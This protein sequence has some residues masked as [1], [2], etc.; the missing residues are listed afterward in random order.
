MGRSLFRHGGKKVPVAV[1]AVDPPQDG[2]EVDILCHHV[3]YKGVTTL[4]SGQGRVV[5][6]AVLQCVQDVKGT[7]LW[8]EYPGG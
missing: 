6:D 2:R 1:D 3:V 7:A 4:C 5:C 8:S